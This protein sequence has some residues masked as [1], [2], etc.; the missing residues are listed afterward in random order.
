MEKDIQY[1]YIEPGKHSFKSFY[2][3]IFEIELEKGKIYYLGL[4]ALGGQWKLKGQ[5]KPL[6]EQEGKD[7]IIASKLTKYF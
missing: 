5:F 2:G 4:E 6:N 3:D 7:K 1:K